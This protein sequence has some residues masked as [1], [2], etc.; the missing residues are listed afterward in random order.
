MRHDLL[1]TFLACAI[2]LLPVAVEGAS[3][4][5]LRLE[6]KVG[7]RSTRTAPSLEGESGTQ[8]RIAYRIRN[9]GG[10]D[11]W[12]VFVRAYTTLG[13]V[14]PEARLRPGPGAGRALER[15]I[16]LTLAQ[17][18]RELCLEAR[19]QQLDIQESPEANTDDN[20]LCRRIRV[21]DPDGGG[22]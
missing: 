15:Q 6:W 2:G 9:V 12:A 14:G 21:T 11:A 7:S 17:G 20:R 22:R 4:P 13:T 16:V 19:L 1:L 5:D 10:R 3:A 18:M 8:L